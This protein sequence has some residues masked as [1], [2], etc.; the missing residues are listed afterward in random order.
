VAIALKHFK[1]TNTTF[2]LK[3]NKYVTEYDFLLQIKELRYTE[4][5][6]VLLNLLD[7]HPEVCIL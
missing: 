3:L 5:I 7:S 2:D 1:K 6:K 4:S